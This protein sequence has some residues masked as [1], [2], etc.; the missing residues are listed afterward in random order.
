MN[1]SM[2]LQNGQ[3]NEMPHLF[4]DPDDHVACAC[5]PLVEELIESTNWVG[6]TKRLLAYARYRLSRHGALAGRYNNKADDYVQD[7]VMLFMDGTRRYPCGSGKTLFGFLCGVVDSLIS[8]D[9]EKARRRGPEMFIGCERGED[10]ELD[11]YAEERLSA[12]S[13]FED[14]IIADD[15]LSRFLGCLAPD[16]VEYARL[17]ATAEQMTAEE[18]ADV[19]DV[20]VSEI[21]NMDKRLRRRRPQWNRM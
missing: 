12:R 9:A 1:A 14:R 7:A 10:A 18:Y 20:P 5:E 21:R 2:P 11:E 8:H 15:E 3:K 13:D 17:R 16:L 4:P 19:L 6:T